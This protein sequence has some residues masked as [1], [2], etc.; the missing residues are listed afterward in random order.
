MYKYS[1]GSDY[2]FTESL[3][4][5]V[6]SPAS[7]HILDFRLNLYIDQILG[8]EVT[9][10]VA[11]ISGF[12]K[13]D[14]DTLTVKIRI[15]SYPEDSVEADAATIAD[16]ELTVR[17]SDSS[18]GEFV[19]YH[20]DVD[21]APS[22]TIPSNLWFEG[23]MGVIDPGGFVDRYPSGANISSFLPKVNKFEPTTINVFS[24]HRVNEVQCRYALPLFASSTDPLGQQYSAVTSATGYVKLLGGDNCVVSLQESTNTIA[25]TA[26]IGANGTDSERCGIWGNPSSTGGKQCNQVIHSVSGVAPTSTGDIT[27]TADS[28]LQVSTVERADIP[29]QALRD[30]VVNNTSMGHIDTCIYIGYTQLNGNDS[31]YECDLG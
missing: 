10:V 30:F 9:T 4:T 27:I 26:L 8:T 20:F 29:N 31:I 3:G 6:G 16:L 18:V 7:K 21:D 2:P 28:P 25:L 24:R 13:V 1:E 17:R 22:S 15:K 19:R 5:A 23:F 14:S 11:A 12:T